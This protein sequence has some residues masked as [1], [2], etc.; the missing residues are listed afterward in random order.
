MTIDYGKPVRETTVANFRQAD[1]LVVETGS[2]AGRLP[3][4]RPF[5]EAPSRPPGVSAGHQPRRQGPSLAVP[6]SITGPD[7]DPPEGVGRGLPPAGGH[8]VR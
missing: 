6:W 4:T 8:K 2:R 1:G 3:T 5:T 7:T